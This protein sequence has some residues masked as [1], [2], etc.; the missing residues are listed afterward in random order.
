MLEF[1]HVEDVWRLFDRA[2][3]ANA[4][5]RPT[6]RRGGPD[7]PALEFHAMLTPA[8]A[9][10]APMTSHFYYFRSAGGGHIDRPYMRFIG[11]Q[12]LGPAESRAAPSPRAG[13]RAIS[14]PPCILKNSLNATFFRQTS[15]FTQTD[16]VFLFVDNA[17]SSSKY[18]WNAFMPVHYLNLLRRRPIAV[19]MAVLSEYFI[20]RIHE[21]SLANE[22]ST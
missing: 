19:S 9:H 5:N 2:Y 17:Y 22:I 13:N 16:A 7:D 1:W 11:Q 3:F 18:F 15:L 20:I 10:V 8:A 14:G 4:E 6:Q 21:Y 12:S